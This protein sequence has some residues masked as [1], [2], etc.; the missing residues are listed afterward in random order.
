MWIC[1]GCSWG[2]IPDFRDLFVCISGSDRSTLLGITDL[3]AGARRPC[4][5][6]VITPIAWAQRVAAAAAAAA[7]NDDDEDDGAAMCGYR[8]FIMADRMLQIERVQ[9]SDEGTY[10]CRVENSVGWREAE[11]KLVVHCTNHFS[12]IIY[13]LFIH[14]GPI[15]KA[16]LCNRSLLFKSSDWLYVFGTGRKYKY[17]WRAH[18]ES[19]PLSRPKCRGIVFHGEETIVSWF[20]FETCSK[21]VEDGAIGQHIRLHISVL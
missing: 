1:P 10:V 8:S 15:T 17:N 4:W 5:I 6:V 7:D 3:S 19:K 21:V 18:R 16:I 9:I 14:R 12:Y 13:T 2:R 20:D 11:A